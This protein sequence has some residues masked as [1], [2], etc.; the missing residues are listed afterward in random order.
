MRTVLVVLRG[1]KTG[2]VPKRMSGPTRVP[3]LRGNG[4]QINAVEVAVRHL[5]TG[6]QSRAALGAGM[7]RRRRRRPSVR[8]WPAAC[9]LRSLDLDGCPRLRRL[10]AVL[11]ARSG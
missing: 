8:R 3:P 11:R 4:W 6:R 2:A 5:A 9:R 1:A 10:R 7:P